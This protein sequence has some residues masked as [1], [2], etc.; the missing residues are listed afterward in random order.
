[1][2][3]FVVGDIL[4]SGIY[5]LVGVIAGEVGGAIWASFLIAIAFAFL[6]GFSYAELVTKYPA[7]ADASLYVN[8]AFNNGLLTFLVAFSLV[9]AGLS[10]A[11]ALAQVSADHTSRLSSACQPCS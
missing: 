1:L 4:G 3:F 6:I 7:A 9:A 11:G 8:R 2:F 5:A 10:A